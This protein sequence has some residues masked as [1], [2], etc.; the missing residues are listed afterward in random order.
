MGEGE[1]TF[2]KSL[3]AHRKKSGYEEEP[4]LF[5]NRGTLAPCSPLG[6]PTVLWQIQ[7]RGLTQDPG[8]GS[9]VSSPPFPEPV[10][11]L[12]CALIALP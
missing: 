12:C 6:T 11:P 4:S 1:G 5:E 10:T 9:A 7:R 2:L 8:P 3:A